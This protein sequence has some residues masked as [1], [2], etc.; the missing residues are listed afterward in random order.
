MCVCIYVYV[1]AY[2]RMN[3]YVYIYSCTGEDYARYSQGY[4]RSRLA[5][6]YIDKYIKIHR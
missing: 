3:V 1:Y 4:V 5:D 2:V 6:A